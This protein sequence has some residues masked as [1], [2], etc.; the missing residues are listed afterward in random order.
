MTSTDAFISAVL[1]RV[2]S[3]VGVEQLFLFGPEGD[4]FWA[5]RIP[6]QHAD[7]RLLLAALDLLE[8][9]EAEHEKPFVAS[10]P[11]G[12]F[13]VAAFDANED[14]YVV[15]VNDQATGLPAE[16]RVSLARE[17]IRPHVSEIRERLKP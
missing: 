5:A 3:H 15:L 8:S 2:L 12:R 11:N 9:T 10:D 17:A 14:I 4:P 16:A 13:T 6:L 1:T 7:L